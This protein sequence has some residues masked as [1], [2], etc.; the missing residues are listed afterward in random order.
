MRNLG[1]MMKQAQQMQAKM[2]EAQEKIEAM[3]V[4]GASGGGI[5]T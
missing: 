5:G 4:M 3:R 1:E 2:G